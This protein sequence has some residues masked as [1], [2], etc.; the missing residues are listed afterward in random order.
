VRAA[1]LGVMRRCR[2]A[3]ATQLVLE[4]AFV[5]LSRGEPGGAPT[6]VAIGEDGGVQREVDLRAM[7]QQ[8]VG[9][10]WRRRGAAAAASFL[11]AVLTGIYLCNVCSCHETLRRN[12][13]AQL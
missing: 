7:R 9:Q 13:R 3:L 10:T 5:A 2:Y 12:D 6:V 11:A 1:A 8:V 4:A